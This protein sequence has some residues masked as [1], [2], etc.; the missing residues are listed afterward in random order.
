MLAQGLRPSWEHKALQN[1]KVHC[2]DQNPVHENRSTYYD[3]EMN[4]VVGYAAM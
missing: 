2:L 4:A 3:E 1:E